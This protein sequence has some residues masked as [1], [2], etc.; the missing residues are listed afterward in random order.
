MSE[1]YVKGLVSVIIPTHNRAHYLEDALRSIERQSYRPVQAVVVDDGSTD[2]T[3]L[4][5]SEWERRCRPSSGFQVDYCYQENRGACSAR[6]LGIARSEGEFLQFLDSDDVIFPYCMEWAVQHFVEQS[7]DYVYFCV[8]RSDENLVPLPRAYIGQ[9]LSGTTRDI[10]AYLW[11][12]MGAIYRRE[13][14][15]KVGFWNEDL[16]GSQDWEFGARVRLADLRAT[17]DSRVIGLFRD[18]RFQRIGVNK[19]S[20]HYVIS[21]EKACESIEEH[22]ARAGKLDE[23]VK[24]ALARRLFIHA[25]EFG[26]NGFEED[27]QRLL[28]KSL[29]LQEGRGGMLSSLIRS[30]QAVRSRGVARSCLRLNAAKSRM[31][32]ACRRDK[33]TFAAPLEHLQHLPNLQ[34]G[35]YARYDLRGVD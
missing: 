28:A 13:A 21:V 23:T 11:H 2:N 27:K 19:F 7:L 6:N 34:R 5:V 29:V 17:Y 18:H 24:R 25:I 22:A 14:L 9:A 1:N 26:A 30:A 3:R 32:S 33:G 8:H 10:C 35:A 16:T 4:V 15:E 12:T 31:V 20:H